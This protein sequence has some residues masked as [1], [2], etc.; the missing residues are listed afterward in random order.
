MFWIPSRVPP[1]DTLA[2]KARG[3]ALAC[4]DLRKLTLFCDAT[5]KVAGATP[6]VA[7]KELAYR[8]EKPPRQ[9]QGGCR[10]DAVKLTKSRRAKA[11]LTEVFENLSRFFRIP[12]A[13]AR[14][15][16]QNLLNRFIF[17]LT[18]LAIAGYNLS[19]LDLRRYHVYK[20]CYR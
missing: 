10:A 11:V 15:S 20:D 2:V 18:D 7:S 4:G 17:F 19:V 3:P 9:P 14:A 8:Q 1:G 5:R 6:N 12:V 16:G 13:P